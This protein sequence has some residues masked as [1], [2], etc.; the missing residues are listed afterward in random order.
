MLIVKGLRDENTS[1]IK[2]GLISH[3]MIPGFKVTRT[4]RE[5]LLCIGALSF[6]YKFQEF[7]VANKVLHQL[8]SSLKTGN[9]DISRRRDYNKGVLMMFF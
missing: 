1:I 5:T 6:S 3:I 4:K 8:H 9:R 7:V 2:S